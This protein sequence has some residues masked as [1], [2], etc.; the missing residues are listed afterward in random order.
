MATRFELRI[1]PATQSAAQAM[2]SEISAVSQE[3]IAEELRKLLAH[4]HRARGVELIQEFGLFPHILPEIPTSP[5][6]V[7]MVAALPEHASFELA[8]AALGHDLTKAQMTNLGKRLKLSNQE[9]ERIAWLV[10]HGTRLRTAPSLPKSQLYPILA[11]R[12]VRE[13]LDLHR[14]EAM[15][16]GGELRPVEFCEELLHRVPKPYFDPPP[17]LTGDDLMQMG[18]KPGPAF[19]TLL[20]QLRQRQLDA[21]LTSPQEARDWVQKQTWRS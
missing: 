6:R 14:A 5:Q 8:L 20:D 21:E 19:K 11:H 12:G 16:S 13:L 15:A 4:R 9:L 1:D 10:E 2:A 17:L 3:R 18:L 7:G